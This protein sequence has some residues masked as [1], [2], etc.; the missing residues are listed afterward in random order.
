[1]VVNPLWLWQDNL[2]QVSQTLIPGVPVA[3]AITSV[4]DGRAMYTP[5]KP[6]LFSSAVGALL[7]LQSPKLDLIKDVGNQEII[8]KAFIV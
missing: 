7:C 4:P 5:A 8:T 2:L 6:P 3:L 1:M